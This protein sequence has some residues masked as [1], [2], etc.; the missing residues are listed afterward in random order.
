MTQFHNPYNFVPV[1]RSEEIGCI[2]R[3]S[4]GAITNPLGQGA[5]VGH[6][7]YHPGLWTGRIEVQIQVVTPLLIP[8]AINVE[9]VNGHKTFDV[10]TGMDGKALLPVTTLKGALRSAYE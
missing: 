10:R 6:H 7:R 4:D 8:D 9:T 2:E 3:H 5:P 1:G